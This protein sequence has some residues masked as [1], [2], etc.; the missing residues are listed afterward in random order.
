MT[1]TLTFL[2]LGLLLGACAA[3]AAGP[4]PAPADAGLVREA[5]STRDGLRGDARGAEAGG[6]GACYLSGPGPEE[7]LVFVGNAESGTVSVV[8]PRT[9]TVT[10]TIP[11]GNHPGEAQAS[12]DGNLVLVTNVED[13][14]L[15][16]IL[17]AGLRVA[18]T[19]E[20]GSR[21]GL[22][23]VSPDGKD[24]WVHS[25][26][27]GRLAVVDLEGLTVARRLPSA[28]GEARLA[29]DEN[30]PPRVYLARAGDSSLAVWPASGESPVATQHLGGVPRAMAYSKW[31]QAVYVCTSGA[32]PAVEVFSTQ[33]PAAPARIA[34]LE[35]P[36]ACTYLRFS[37]DGRY[38]WLSVRDADTVAL[39]DT[40]TNTLVSTL[41][42]GERP[43]RTL[44]LGDLA[45]TGNLKS[46][47]ISLLQRAPARELAR[48]AVGT[49][50]WDDAQKVGR[51]PL[52]AS[53]D[54]RFA[55]VPSDHCGTLS[56]V[57]LT[58]KKLRGTVLLGAAPGAITV[59]SPSGGASCH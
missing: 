18:K 1:S 36:N 26:G 44:V 53:L 54:G 43:D 49:V 2:S 3:P 46:P 9:C 6:E 11:V 48:V 37:A 40:E 39:L 47:D 16:V 57:D 27:D 45:V 17:R 58:A 5:G 13:G 51:R 22:L 24:A 59:A 14:T 7:E 50:F 30:L 29:F 41:R 38:G 28:P 23:Q 10:K 52:A 34:R 4:S 31:K 33:G 42:A 19:I 21:P 20:V 8:D 12:P 56:I 25:D 55:Y 15:S 32:K 35:L